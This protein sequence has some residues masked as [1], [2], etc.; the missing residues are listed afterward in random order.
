[1][2]KY[3]VFILGVLLFV[4]CSKKEEPNTAEELNAETKQLLCDGDW[5]RVS[6]KLEPAVMLIKQ[7]G[8]GY[9]TLTD[10][11]DIKNFEDYD[12]NFDGFYTF[13]TNGTYDFTSPEYGVSEG[14]YKL[15]KKLIKA[16]SS[17]DKKLDYTISVLNKVDFVS[18][19][20][21]DFMG[22]QT[23]VTMHCKKK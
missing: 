19:F 2:K 20:P 21:L 13:K 4:G 22:Q 5:E 9:Y 11:M 6:L 3:L 7:D 8:S 23:L 15:D 16:V 12:R 18:M 1:M 14:T 10:L 17:S